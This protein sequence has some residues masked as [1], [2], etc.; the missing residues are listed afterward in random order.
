MFNSYILKNIDI[1]MLI[2]F[3]PFSLL[4]LSATRKRFL[5]LAAITFGSFGCSNTNFKKINSA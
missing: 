4:L 1:N 2:L 5:S 3:L